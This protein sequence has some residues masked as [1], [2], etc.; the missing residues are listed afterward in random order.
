MNTKI[1]GSCPLHMRKKASFHGTKTY[2][3]RQQSTVFQLNP[4]CGD[5][6]LDDVEDIYPV[7]S[8]IRDEKQ[9]YACYA[10]YGMDMKKVEKY[11]P[12]VKELQAQFE[13]STQTDRTFELR[14]GWIRI[15]L[16]VLE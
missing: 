10:C 11:Y 7:C 8:N 15:R 9:R 3:Y 6:T 1:R 2:A 14:I 13:K 4:P 12:I 5:V 16:D